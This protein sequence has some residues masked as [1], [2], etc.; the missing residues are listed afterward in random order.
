MDAFV[1]FVFIITF[2]LPQLLNPSLAFSMSAGIALLL[3]IYTL[4]IAIR[5]R[6]VI[7]NISKPKLFLVLLY[8]SL[9]FLAFCRAWISGVLDTSTVVKTSGLAFI[10]VAFMLFSV[11]SIKSKEDLHFYMRMI[12]YGLGCL[13][14]ENLLLYSMGVASGGEYS[15]SAPGV[16][17]SAIGLEIDAAIYSLE[18][19]PKMLGSILVFLA[20]VSFIFLK[21]MKNVWLY[22]PI[23]II[24]T[25]MIVVADARMYLAIIFLLL[26]FLPFHEKLLSQGYLKIYLVSFPLIPLLL[27]IVASYIAEMPGFDIVARNASDNISTISGR[28]D[29]WSSIGTEIKEAN[30]QLF[31]GYGAAGMVNSGINDQVAYMFS[32]G[33]ADTGIKTAHNSILQQLLDKGLIGVIIFITLVCSLVMTFHSDKQTESK[34]FLYGILALML[35]SALNTLFYYASIESYLLF[36]IMISLHV[37]VHF[38]PRHLP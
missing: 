15:Y 1:L 30:A 26:V 25:G 35:A 16:L 19:G 18:A 17:L 5:S 12:I 27:I 13:V 23:A 24:C 14:L 32:G 3:A 38:N 28:T 10:L 22:F 2:R 36:I 20:A 29:I 4:L 9:E 37:S 6:F 33:W 21:E 31:Y 7:K 34:A 11:S 8:L